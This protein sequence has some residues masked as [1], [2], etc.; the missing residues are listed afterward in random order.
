MQHFWEWK[1]KSQNLVQFRETGVFLEMDPSSVSDE[2]CEFF[3]WTASQFAGWEM[4]TGT[5][6]L[7]SSFHPFE[8]H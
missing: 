4:E 5:S 2:M 1:F 6:R 3:Y 7:W 8:G